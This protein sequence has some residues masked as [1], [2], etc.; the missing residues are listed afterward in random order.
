MHVPRARDVKVQLR[1]EF[2]H[3]KR[4]LIRRYDT[5]AEFL[6]TRLPGYPPSCQKSKILP[7]AGDAF[8]LPDWP[9][10]AAPAGQERVSGVLCDV[11]REES[12]DT[13]TELYVDAATSH[14]VRARV[15]SYEP[16]SAARAAKPDITYD[17][18]EFEAKAPPESAFHLPDDHEG[19]IKACE[20]R[21]HDIGFPYVHLFHTVLRA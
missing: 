11:F 19:G 12:G 5:K 1:V 17:V 14:P 15:S 2:E 20:R 4:T 9:A 3:T 13:V 6:V 8:P 21:P 16:G 7:G 18:V 10:G